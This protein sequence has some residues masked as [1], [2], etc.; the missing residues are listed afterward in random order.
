MKI[1]NRL[2]LT[3]IKHCNEKIKD[4]KKKSSNPDMLSFDNL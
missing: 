1:C 3:H 4:T 2:S